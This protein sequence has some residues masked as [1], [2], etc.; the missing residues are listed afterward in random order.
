MH[1][2]TVAWFAL[3]TLIQWIIIYLVDGII[4][5]LNYW[6]QAN[7]SISSWQDNL[8]EWHFT[9]RGP[10][11]SDFAGG[12]YHGRI[13]LPPEYPMK[14]PS[15]MLL[16]VSIA[17]ANSHSKACFSQSVSGVIF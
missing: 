10:P 2:H 5:S 6:G 12:R 8:F 13:T 1:V 11:D 4:Q 14:P 9:V 16:T 17:K 3:L 15:I 7:T